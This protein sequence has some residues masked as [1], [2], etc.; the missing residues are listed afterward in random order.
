LEKAKLD[1]LM[2]SAPG[3][4]NTTDPGNV[5]SDGG[6]STVTYVTAPEAIASNTILMMTTKV[7]LS[8]PNGHQMVA[9]ALLDPAS[10]ASFVTE[11]VVQ[12]LKLH[13]QKQEITINGIGDT[14]CSTQSNSVV[15]MNLRSTQSS[16][17]LDNVQALVL[18][19]LTKCLP[20]TT[21]LNREL[22]TSIFS[23]AC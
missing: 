23:Q 5:A 12:C 6:I 15:N 3:A 9:R 1:T 20:V 8:G 19:S 13:K 2:V 21:L 4:S 14:R 10:T 7:I 22:A 11:R 18:P 17:A 16:S